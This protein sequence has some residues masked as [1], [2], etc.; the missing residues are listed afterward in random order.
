MFKVTK[1][2]HGTFSWADCSSTNAAISKNF[3]MDIMGWDKDEIPMGEGATYTMFK[4]DGENVAALAQMRPEMIAMNIPSFWLSYITVD[5]VDAVAAKVTG[6]GGSL[7][8]EPFDV[9]DS[10]RMAIVQDPTGAEVGL[11][12]AKNHIGASLVNK[13]GAMT[14][15]ELVTKDLEAAKTFYAGLLGWDYSQVE[16][17]GYHIIMNKGRMN[18]GMMTMPDPAQAAGIPANWGVYFTVAS[19]ETTMAKVQALGG[20]IMMPPQ[21]G[22]GGQFIMTQDSAGAMVAFIETQTPDPWIES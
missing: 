5:D 4:T 13:V 15:N 3:Y 11:W 16:G 19:L 18:G 14:W 10:G 20:K 6:L 8:A 12:Q 9:F 17:S 22:G 1:Y 2:P 7:T 21:S